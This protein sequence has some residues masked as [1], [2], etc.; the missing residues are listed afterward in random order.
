MDQQ[1]L[2]AP[3]SRYYIK[4]CALCGEMF[5]PISPK[6]NA[7]SIVCALILQSKVMSNGCVEWQGSKVHWGY[8]YFRHFGIRKRAHV[9]AWELVNG[10]V[11][12]GLL[13]RHKCDNPPCI[14]VEH[15]EPGTEIDNKADMVSRGRSARGERHSQSKLT[16]TDVRL[17]RCLGAHGA[18]SHSKIAKQIGCATVTI[19]DVLRGKSWSWLK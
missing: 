7:C 12:E 13:L 19:G 15:L 11:P 2:R 8:G 16:E 14:K 6:T 5:Q 18:L 10:K 4:P 9:V 17:I 3:I 1:S